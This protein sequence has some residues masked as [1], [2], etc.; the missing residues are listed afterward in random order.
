MSIL[1]L[2]A[3]RTPLGAFGGALR[4][5]DAVTLG[6]LAIRQALS[7]HAGLDIA[8]VFLG[9]AFP[10]GLGPHPARQAIQAAGLSCPA[11]TLNQAEGGGFASVMLACRALQKPTPSF[12]LA[13]SFESPSNVPYLLPTARWGHRMGET[14]LLDGLIQDGPHSVKPMEPATGNARLPLPPGAFAMDIPDRKGMHRLDGDE[15]DDRNGD[16]DGCAD[17]A[18]ALLLASEAALTSIHAPI[19]GRI[20]GWSTEPPDVALSALKERSE[21]HTIHVWEP[22]SYAPAGGGPL[23]VDRLHALSKMDRRFGFTSI[24]TG[25]DTWISLLLEH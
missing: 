16:G 6:S 19:L 3:V 24:A 12:A 14:E 25:D 18:A 20:C 21:S 8:E 7:Q 2:S 17:G 4:N 15:V 10:A 5:V 9:C 23:L 1:V 13:G 22:V 11:W